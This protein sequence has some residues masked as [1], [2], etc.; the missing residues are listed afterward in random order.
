MADPKQQEFA[1]FKS[2]QEASSQT[3]EYLMDTSVQLQD[4]MD[5]IRGENVIFRDVALQQAKDLKTEQEINQNLTSKLIR[6]K[7]LLDAT[8]DELQKEKQEKANLKKEL[9]ESK[10]ELE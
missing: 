10:K 8:D 5:G 1:R 6:T 3:D 4:T 7:K 9:E 2:L